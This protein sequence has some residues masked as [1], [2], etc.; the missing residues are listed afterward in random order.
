MLPRRSCLKTHRGLCRFDKHDQPGR[1]INP[2]ACP[3]IAYEESRPIGFALV[4]KGSH[5]GSD[6]EVWDMHEFFIL[7][8]YRSSGLGFWLALPFTHK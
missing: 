7:R 3:F 6:S 8:P 1:M 2:D 4:T 5:L